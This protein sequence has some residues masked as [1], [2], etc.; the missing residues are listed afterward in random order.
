MP[1][2]SL[3]SPYASA[4]SAPVAR[5]LLDAE[6][7]LA[8]AR[9]EAGIREQILANGCNRLLR[10]AAASGGATCGE[11]PEG[12]LGRGNNRLVFSPF[13]SAERTEGESCNLAAPEAQ[14]S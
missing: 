7:G 13:V 12:C 9:L 2:A 8:G 6:L 14:P 3:A 1:A 11:V 5:S 10:V 4:S